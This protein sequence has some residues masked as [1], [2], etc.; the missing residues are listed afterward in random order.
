MGKSTVFDLVL[1]IVML[2]SL[3]VVFALLVAPFINVWNKTA[4][5]VAT[6]H[7]LEITDSLANTRQMILGKIKNL[8]SQPHQGTKIEVVAIGAGVNMLARESSFA[9]E[10]E[11]LMA[12]G[13]IFSACELALTSLSTS[14]RH[15]IDLIEGVKRVPDGHRYAEGLKNDGYIDEMI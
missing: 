14:I 8:L 3:V 2:G 13:V 11:G 1:Q 7:V 5:P 9:R 15:G 12:K 10:V 4:V 6:Q